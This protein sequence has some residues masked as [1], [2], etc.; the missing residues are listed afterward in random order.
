MM[1]NKNTVTES[2]EETAACEAL[3]ANT[4]A[5]SAAYQK[6]LAE[7]Q[8][9]AAAKLDRQLRE[10]SAQLA[11]A[12]PH[13]APSTDLR[14]RILQATAPQT[15]RM[16]DYRKATKEDPRFYKWG[17]YVAA[18]FLVMASLY[19]L[20]VGR[21]L[22]TANK[23]ILAL[24]SQLN[25][26]AAINQESNNAVAAF[27]DPRS[28]YLTW[29]ENGKPFGRGLVNPATH[30]ALLIFPQELVQPGTR[31]Q[32]AMNVNGSKVDFKTTMIVAPANQ[33]ALQLPSDKVNFALKSPE[34]ES[35]RTAPPTK[36][37][38]AGLNSTSK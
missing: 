16:E 36:I 23:N 11:A 22:E 7:D 5:E 21:N 12:S 3:G 33:I 14:A 28:V 24:Q 29:N 1:D 8:T 37:E 17:F 15:F 9:G 34:V 2:L 19:N 25:Q 26:A 30:Q 31:M 6:T 4:A 38:F 32:L 20:S 27:I 35:G 10:T 18:A 13:L